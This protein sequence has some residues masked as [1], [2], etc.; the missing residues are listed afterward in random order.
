MLL[1]VLFAGLSRSDTQEAEG[2]VASLYSTYLCRFPNLLTNDLPLARF[3][4]FDGIQQ[5]LALASESV[6]RT[7]ALARQITSSSAKSA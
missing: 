7:Y 1:G 4:F 2:A 3:V 5:C 6:S